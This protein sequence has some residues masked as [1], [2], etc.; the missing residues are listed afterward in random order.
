MLDQRRDRCTSDA[1]EPGTACERRSRGRGWSHD[2]AVRHALVAR[3]ASVLASVVVW[4]SASAGPSARRSRGARRSSAAT[5]VF[6]LMFWCYGVVPAPVAHAGPTTSSAGAPTS[7]ILGPART[8]PLAESLEHLTA[9]VRRHRTQALRDI[10][11]A[12]IYGVFLGLQIASS[13]GGRT[14]AR[15]RS[16][17][18]GLEERTTAYGRPLVRKA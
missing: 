6:V 7:C 15:P 12:V 11:V 13:R 10:I 9:A 5:Y 3:L 2:V 14:A 16:Q 1:A 8:A 18:A 4:L 17:A